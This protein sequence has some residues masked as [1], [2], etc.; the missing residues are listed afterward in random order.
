MYDIKEIRD[1][2]IGKH[3]S[4]ITIYGSIGSPHLLPKYIPKK[5][6]IREI[7]YQMVEDGVTD[8]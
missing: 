2:Y 7:T 3:Y 6:L 1:W 8:S 5:L 4:Y